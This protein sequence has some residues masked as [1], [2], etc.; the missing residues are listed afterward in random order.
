MGQTTS[1]SAAILVVRRFHVHVLLCL[2]QSFITQNACCTIKSCKISI[3][4]EARKVTCPNEQARPS[5]PPPLPLSSHH[6][7]PWGL[8][9]GGRGEA[10]STTSINE[11]KPPQA[12]RLV[13][14]R[15]FPGGSLRLLW[16]NWSQKMLPNESEMRAGKGRGN[17]AYPEGR[18][19]IK[20]TGSR[21]KSQKE[22]TAERMRWN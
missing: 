19:E 10:I 20:G 12:F 2:H 3:W 5:L 7:C 13:E 6:H 22:R 8:R 9:A 4:G 17:Q 15:T 21:G 14:M 16:D 11:R 18:R 1:V